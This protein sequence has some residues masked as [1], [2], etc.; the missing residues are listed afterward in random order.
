MK[1]FLNQIIILASLGAS[2]TL[3]LGQ[4]D[5]A[6][7]Y[8]ALPPE[9]YGV[10]DSG[11]TLS[12]AARKDLIAR[13]RN[14]DATVK[15]SVIV[16][17]ANGFLQVSASDSGERHHL[18]MVLFRQPDATALIALSAAENFE[19]V[20]ENGGGEATDFFAFY[21]VEDTGWRNV[22]AEFAPKWPLKDVYLELPRYGTTIELYDRGKKNQIAIWKRKGSG[23]VSL[24]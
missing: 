16:D 1:P 3:S 15:D 23:F 20:D 7:Y 10:V 13:A 19:Q 2:A 6:E 17:V 24:P 5:I 18:T 11:P 4:E 21:V 14:H 22:T 8:L 12:L 9:I